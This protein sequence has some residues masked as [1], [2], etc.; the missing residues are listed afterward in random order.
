MARRPA[1]PTGPDDITLD[2]VRQ[3]LAHSAGFEPS[4]LQAIHAEPLDSGRGLLSTVIRCCLVWSADGPPLPGSVIVK[5]PSRNRKTARLA[6][7]LKL[8]R[9]EYVFYQRIRLL[10]GIRAPALLYGDF[11]PFSH[12]FVIVM[13]DLADSE[14]VSQINGASHAQ[15]KRAARAVARMHARYWNNFDHTALSSVPDYTRKYRRLTQLA[16]QLSLAPTLDRFGNLFNPA[17]RRLARIYG[18]RLADHMAQI[19]TGPRTFTHGD[20][21]AD[22][23]FFGNHGAGDVV[24]I[25]WQNC[26]IHS[27]LRDITYFLSTSLTTKTR[28]T[29]ERDAVAEY[30]DALIRGGVG[31]YSFDACWRDYRRV[32]LSCLIGPVLTCGSLHFSDDASRRTMEIGLSRTLAAIEDLRAEEFLPGRP[33]A[34]SVGHVASMLTAG[35]A[36]ACR[37]IGTSR[38]D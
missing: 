31:G 8:Y 13:E 12:R 37:K 27:G 29:T 9:H 21:R 30:H 33:R 34:F 7:I 3:A 36:R 5:L 25:D 14:C 24:A 4:R 6:R 26:G 22:N 16:Y 23:L 1:I 35:V 38:P 32:M 11:A 10:S 20:F 18:T 17:M 2:W 19:S 28:R 15:A